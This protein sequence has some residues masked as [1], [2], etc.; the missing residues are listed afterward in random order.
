MSLAAAV[1]RKPMTETRDIEVPIPRGFVLASGDVLRDAHILLRRHGAE[2]G[3]QIIAMGG[4][5]AGR[6]VCGVKGWWAHT[7]VDHHAVDLDRFGVIGFEFAPVEDERVRITPQDQARLVEI[8]LDGIKAPR[9]HAFVGASYG[10]MVGL[11]M[12]ATAPQ[13][14]GRLCVIS[15]AHKPSAQ[16]LAWRG[17]QRRIVEFAL[18]Q[19]AGAEGLSLARQLAMITYRTP[20]EFE[21]RFGAGVDADG[22]GEV[23]RYLEAR[24]ADYA[25]KYGPRRWLSLSESIDRYLVD[26]RAVAVP[27]IVVASPDDQLAPLE[28][29]QALAQALPQLRRFELLPSL[30]GHDAFL[31][32]P[33]QLGPLIR[34]F[35]EDPA[36]G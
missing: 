23:D 34:T 31:K 26:P 10:A 32:E 5:S 36:Y 4:I 3:P 27:T 1:G 6:D 19:G 14:L 2:N 21:A 13:R 33:A 8:A 24:G 17:V 20:K 28:D 12:A 22:R 30:F 11:A 25:Q 9:L 35:L 15:A 16:S 18:E 7:F 29:M